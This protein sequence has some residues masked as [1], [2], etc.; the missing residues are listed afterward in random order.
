[1]CLG[2]LRGGEEDDVPMDVMNEIVLDSKHM[3]IDV[4]LVK[5]GSRLCGSGG[6]LGSAPLVQSKSY[7][8]CKVQSLGTWGV[9]VALHT[10]GLDTAPLGTT[11]SS[12]VLRSDGVCIHDNEVVHRLDC[13]FEAGDVIG[14]CYD[15]VSLRFFLNGRDLDVPMQAKGRALYSCFYVDE[16]AIMDVAFSK[17]A[18]QVPHG[19]TQVMVEHSIM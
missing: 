14:C 18:M 1:M 17:F 16:G 12:W 3:G 4:V 2:C 13:A 9:G 8:E 19:Y 15:H 10:V 11:V 5:Q 7:F 6:V